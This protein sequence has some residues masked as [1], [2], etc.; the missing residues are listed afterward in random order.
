MKTELLNNPNTMLVLDMAFV[1]LNC[2]P[3]DYDVPEEVREIQWIVDNS[4]FTYNHN[5][6]SGVY[7]F[8]FNLGML[9]FFVET[10]KNYPENLIKELNAIKD[11]GYNYILFHQ[12][13]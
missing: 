11:K 13:C 9:D 3:D 5:G 6:E 2:V 12:N 7:D 10:D 4:S 8:I 1:E